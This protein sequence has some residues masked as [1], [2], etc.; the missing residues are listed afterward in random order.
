MARGG[1]AHGGGLSVSWA[2]YLFALQESNYCNDGVVGVIKRLECLSCNVA[3]IDIAEMQRG[4]C[5][6]GCSPKGACSSTDQR[7]R[8]DASTE[9]EIEEQMH[10]LVLA[11]YLLLCKRLAAALS[12]NGQNI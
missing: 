7:Q 10:G 11:I 3:E 5:Q 6:C 4:R 8:S 1:A 9:K 2:G 12:G